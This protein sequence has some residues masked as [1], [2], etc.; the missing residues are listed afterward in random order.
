MLFTCTVPF[1]RSKE[2][3]HIPALDRVKEAEAGSFECMALS[4]TETDSLRIAACT[5]EAL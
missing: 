4:E 3:S 1:M 2:L 5:R